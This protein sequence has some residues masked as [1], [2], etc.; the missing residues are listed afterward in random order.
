MPERSVE[1]RTADVEQVREVV[2]EL[3]CP[4]QLFAHPVRYDAHLR[5]DELGGLSFT[6][7]GYGERVE[8][9]VS[10]RQPRFLMQLALRGAFDAR[11]VGPEHRVTGA[12]V[13]VVRPKTPL[14]MRWTS[15]C[16]MLVVG[17]DLGDL[18]AQARALAGADIDL[19]SVLP[20]IVPLTGAG[21]GL[22]RYIEFLRSESQRSDSRSWSG[23]GARPAVQMLLALLLD[24]VDKCG[25]AAGPGRAWYVKRAEA[26][27]D[28]NL[29]NQ[30]GVADVVASSGV[31]MR[32]LYYG[33]RT[34]HGI[35]PMAWLKQRR[36][37]RVKDELAGADPAETSVTDVALRWGFVHL[38]RLAIDYRARFGESP[39]Q[40]LRR[41][42]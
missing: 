31:S 33:F 41:K 13:Q 20:E 5:H 28:A 8:I 21:A 7:I 23:R 36:L 39:S 14:R 32:T 38:G 27:M 37:A 22:G 35:A 34:S 19:P 18:S 4:F 9:D 10:E 42:W 40:T 16:R 12:S 2:G 17:A 30:I 24:A 6:T 25:Q 11:T 3:L 1:V 15:D 26:F 29:E